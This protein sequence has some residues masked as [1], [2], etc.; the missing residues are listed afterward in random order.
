[1]WKEFKKFALRGNVIDLAVGVIIGGAFG[2]IVSSLVNDIIMPFIGLITAGVDF[3][4]LV[5]VIKAA[6]IEGGVTVSPAVTI[7]YGSFIQNVFD[8]FIIALT[9]FLA[10]RALNYRRIQQES[11]DKLEKDR[12]AAEQ[13]KLDALK[14]KEPTVV[15]LLSDIKTLL[16]HQDKE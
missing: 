2:K 3:K 13:A 5:W 7:A 15:E 10:V 12:L 14:P 16:Q 1:M 11:K 8:F 9:I 4:S 6:V